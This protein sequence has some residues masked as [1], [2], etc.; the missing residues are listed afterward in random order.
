[1]TQLFLERE[2]ILPRLDGI[3]KNIKRLKELAKLP[4]KDFAQGDPYDLAHHHLR[5]VLE[6]FFIFLLTSCLGFREHGPWNTR[7][8]PSVWAKIRLF[9]RI[10]P[11]KN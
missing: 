8:S 9:P 7:K 6:A 1:M 10:L 5:L 11:N 2:A 3:R 4:F